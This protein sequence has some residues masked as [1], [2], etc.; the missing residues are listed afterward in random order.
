LNVQEE[1][2]TPLPIHPIAISSIHQFDHLFPEE[3][4]T[5]LLAKRDIQ[6]YIELIPGSIPPN[7]PEYRMN[8]EETMDIKR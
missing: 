5:G 8:P 3:I 1:P 6:H 2:E 7:K 4:P